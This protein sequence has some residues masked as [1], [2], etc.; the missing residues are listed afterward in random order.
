MKTDIAAIVAA[1]LL[2]AGL[3][4]IGPTLDAADPYITRAPDTIRQATDTAALMLHW[5]AAADAQA[6]AIGRQ[7]DSMSDTE[8]MAGVVLEPAPAD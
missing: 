8:R 1:F 4:A 2:I 7:Y 5:Q 3:G 6:E